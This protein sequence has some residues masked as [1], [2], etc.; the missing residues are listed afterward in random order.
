MVQIVGQVV[1]TVRCM[2]LL[3]TRGPQRLWRHARWQGLHW[4]NAHG[5][6]VAF[7]AGTTVG[8]SDEALH[9]GSGSMPV[10]CI[11]GHFCYAVAVGAQSGG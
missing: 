7:T 9:G 11:H 5:L 1:S 4:R 10:T 2:L 3:L 6:P 8:R